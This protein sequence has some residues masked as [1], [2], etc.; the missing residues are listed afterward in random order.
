[1]TVVPNYAKPSINNES[2][3]VTFLIPIRNG[4][5]YLTNLFSSLQTMVRKTDEILVID[6]GSEDDTFLKL[7][8]YSVDNLRIIRNS[9]PGL[10][11]ALNL[12]LKESQNILIARVDVDDSYL[13]G[14]IPRQLE[15][16][17]NNTVAV[18]SDYLFRDKFNKS[19]GTIYSAIFPSAVSVS[20]ISSQRTAHPSVLFR[21]DA[22]LDVGGY[23][24]D[25]FP[26]EDLSLWLRLS[27]VGDLKSAPSTLLKYYLNPFGVSASKSNLMKIKKIEHLTNIGINSKDVSNLNLNFEKIMN[28]YDAY[29]NSA[30]RKLLLARELMILG[31]FT[32][33]K[34]TEF[35]NGIRIISRT[36]L[37]EKSASVNAIRLII[38]R[39]KRKYYLKQS[40]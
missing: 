20:L 31:K 30:E 19:L 2:I 25:D 5:Q 34:S 12:G 11:N 15:F 33:F 17:D 38:D 28:N 39:L 36:M 40:H 4:S 8:E 23:R 9:K 21:K 27:R 13:S 35:N 18:F 16:L 32:K 26:A 10:V 37:T 24:A 6:D 3:P 14:R 1:M 7:H 29:P 22:V